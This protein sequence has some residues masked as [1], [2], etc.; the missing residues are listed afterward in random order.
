MQD[1]WLVRPF[2]SSSLRS[3]PRRI[4]SAVRQK[5]LPGTGNLFRLRTTFTNYWQKVIENSTS[6]VRL[7]SIS[8][9]RSHQFLAIPHLDSKGLGDQGES[10][11]QG[12]E[13][14]GV[15][16]S[17]HRPTTLPDS[18]QWLLT[19]NLRPVLLTND[20]MYKG[21]GVTKFYFS[22]SGVFPFM[23]RKKKKKRKTWNLWFTIL[24][25]LRLLWEGLC[26]YSFD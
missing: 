23:H 13:R 7:F 2:S 24:L 20:H 11:G 1:T 9:V 10:R 12:W 15:V 25:S 17:L 4:R 3:D 21:V 14:S 6:R 16:S 19:L 22:S 18:G 26:D 8:S 5:P